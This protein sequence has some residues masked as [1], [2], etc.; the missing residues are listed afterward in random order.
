MAMRSASEAERLSTFCCASMTL[1]RASRCGNRLNCWNTMP[2]CSRTL[3]TS[4]LGSVMSLPSKMIEPPV[5]SSRRFRQRSIVDLPEPDGPRMTSPRWMSSEMSRRT[6]R[7]PKLLRRFWMRM[8]ASSAAGAAG[9]DAV[10][11]MIG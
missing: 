2:I 7:S 3:L 8:I 4:T 6:S 5:G 9:V 11:A 1:C 10:S